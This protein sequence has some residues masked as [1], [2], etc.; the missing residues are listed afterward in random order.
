M[1]IELSNFIINFISNTFMIFTW[2][3]LFRLVFPNNNI[4][5]NFIREI[6]KWKNPKGKS[7]DYNPK[8]CIKLHFENV[9]KDIS[10]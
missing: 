1:L 8:S 2:V 7:F 6:F 5:S 9:S 10:N 4:T 3:G